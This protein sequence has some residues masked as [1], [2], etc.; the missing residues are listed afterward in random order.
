MYVSRISGCL[1]NELW[2]LDDQRPATPV[3]IAGDDRTRRVE[4]AGERRK[5]GAI[6]SFETRGE[7]GRRDFLALPCAVYVLTRRI[8]VL[9]PFNRLAD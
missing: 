5:S 8:I 7:R 1:P 3:E 9:I 6:N 4:I 2:T